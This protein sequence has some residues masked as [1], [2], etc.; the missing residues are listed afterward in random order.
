MGYDRDRIIVDAGGVGYQVLPSTGVLR[1]KVKIGEEIRLF[2]YTHVREDQLALFGFSGLEEKQMFELLLSVSGVGPKSA[3]A[4][5]SRGNPEEVR[6][7]VANADVEF[8]TS[9]PG[10]GKK[11]SQRIIIDL[12]SKLGDL[13]ELDLKGEKEP[14][15]KEL[16]TALKS[17]GFSPEEAGAAVKRVDLELPLDQQIRSALKENG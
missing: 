9:V 1:N 7:A 4:V 14:A 11:T 17:M 13:A 2:I 10:L 12:K 15:A 5:L 6:E 8:F 16:I 3:L